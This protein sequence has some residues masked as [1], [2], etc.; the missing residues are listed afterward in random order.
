VAAAMK[1]EEMSMAV[2]P[3]CKV[4]TTLRRCDRCGNVWHCRHKPGRE[5]TSIN[6]CE[7]C[8]AV[9]RFTLIR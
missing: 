6:R 8:G 5:T 1:S 2:C 7:Q 4:S 9:D 3:W